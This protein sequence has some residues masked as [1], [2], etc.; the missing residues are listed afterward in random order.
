MSISGG[1][2]VSTRMGDRIKDKREGGM[3]VGGSL[4]SIPPHALYTTSSSKPTSATSSNTSK[5]VN[6]YENMKVRR[7]IDP[8]TWRGTSGVHQN[9]YVS[10]S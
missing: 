5:T 2:D 7:G 1:P 6:E 4:A 10:W 8:G 3:L 9:F